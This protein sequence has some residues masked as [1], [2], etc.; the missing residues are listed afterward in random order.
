MVGDG[1]HSDTPGFAGILTDADIRSS[2]ACMK[3]NWPEHERRYETDITRRERQSSEQWAT[4]G[5][6]S[7]PL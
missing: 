6:A 3:S 5:T 7:S 1:Y 4:L 2:L